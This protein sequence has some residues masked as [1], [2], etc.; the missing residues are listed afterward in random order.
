MRVQVAAS[1]SVNES[2]SVTILDKSW[3]SFRIEIWFVTVRVEEPIVVGIFVVVTG[4]LLLSRSF[5][6]CLN[7]GMKKTTTIP[8]VLKCNARTECNFK[9]RVLADFSPTKI[10]LEKGGHLRISWT[11]ILE[12]KEVEVEGEHVHHQGDDDE[13]DY[14]EDE[15]LE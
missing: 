8:H 4:N 12:D 3:R 6:V 5:G 14:A 13:A 9:R 1:L 10:C 15:V 2:D 11:T 7:V